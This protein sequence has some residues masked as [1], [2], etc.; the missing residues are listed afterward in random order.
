MDQQIIWDVF[1]NT[2]EAA[3]I[4]EVEDD[5]TKAVRS[6]LDRLAE[7]RIGE[8]GRLME[9]ALPFEEPE[10]GHR[11]MSHLFAIHPGS[12]YTL[13]NAP[14]KV[15]AARRSI[16]FRLAHGGGHTGWSRAWIINFFARFHDGD[17]AHAHL[18]ALL[19]KSTLENLFDTHPPFQIDGNFGGTAGIAEMLIQSHTDQL[20]LLP[21]LP[22]AWASGSVTGLRARGGFEVDMHWKDGQLTEAAIRSITGQ[23]LIVR[24]GDRTFKPNLAKGETWR[25]SP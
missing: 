20:E 2:L 6:A 16:D 3:R 8:D 21:A 11:H 22:S 23:P 7:A 15:A 25:W 14:E 18:L 19:R 9:W 13:R 4:L 24:Y 10:P 5:L 17:E 1:N 12:Q